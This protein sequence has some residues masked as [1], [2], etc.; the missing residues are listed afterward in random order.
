MKKYVKPAI[1]LESFELTQ[2]I[3]GNCEFVMNATA[4]GACKAT[5]IDGKT[6]GAPAGLT[7]FNSGNCFATPQ[8][9]DIFCYYSSA[10]GWNLA[11]S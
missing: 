10:N 7:I 8:Q 2:H 9:Y 1:F 5:L 6:A 4:D 11:T 3:A